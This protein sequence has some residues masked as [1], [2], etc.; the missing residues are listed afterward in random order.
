MIRTIL[1][2]LSAIPLLSLC[3]Y[4]YYTTRV[5]PVFAKTEPAAIQSKHKT[6]IDTPPLQREDL[7]EKDD[8]K[9]W[10]PEF[11]TDP[12]DYYEEYELPKHS[13]A[14]DEPQTT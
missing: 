6:N 5:Y 4:N 1:F 13:E 3:L 9:T 12:N 11:N 8:G 2:L 10:Y 7:L 14:D